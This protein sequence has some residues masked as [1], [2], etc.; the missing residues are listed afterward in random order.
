MSRD[1]EN[2]WVTLATFTTLTNGQSAAAVSATSGLLK[3]LRWNVNAL[4]GATAIVFSIS[5]ML[6][7]CSCA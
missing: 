6:R 2:G 5:G 3:Y 7:K 4:G 1:S